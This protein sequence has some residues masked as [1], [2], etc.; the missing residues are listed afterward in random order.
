MFVA[1]II[2][3][4][5]PRQG[6]H[7]GVHLRRHHTAACMCSPGGGLDLTLGGAPQCALPRYVRAS[8]PSCERCDVETDHV[9]AQNTRRDAIQDIWNMWSVAH[10]ST[11]C[12]VMLQMPRGRWWR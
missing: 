3:A 1:L 9:L 7:Q 10:R 4:F 5:W 2:F 8:E 11:Q 6:A 12:G